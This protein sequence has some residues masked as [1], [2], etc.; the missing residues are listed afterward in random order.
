ML[1]I[2][3]GP[4]IMLGKFTRY[5]SCF[6]IEANSGAASLA[7]MKG[8]AIISP[9]ISADINGVDKFDCI[10]LIDVFEHLT[11]PFEIVKLAFSRLKNGGRLFI[12]TGR[13]DCIPF[14]LL[15]PHYWYFKISQH[16]VFLNKTH[17]QW[18]QNQLPNS[19]LKYSKIGHYKSSTISFV[20]SCFKL[21]K[22][23]IETRLRR[24]LGLGL[25][26]VP[27]DIL[28]DFK[29]HYLIEINNTTQKN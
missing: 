6:G 17:L 5:H 10:M 16:I 22:W 1:D 19:S 29:D 20:R 15:G 8:I 26:Q 23:S 11:T 25:K 27:F 2:G 14:R 3:C 28:R 13:T 9:W 4:G 7:R 21:L 12:V 24:S 18:L